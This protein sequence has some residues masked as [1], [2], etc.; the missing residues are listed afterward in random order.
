MFKRLRSKHG[1][2]LSPELAFEPGHFYSP[3]VDREYIR[4]HEQHI[5]STNDALLG[6]D[7]NDSSH[8]HILRTIFPRFIRDFDYPEQ[9]KDSDALQGF[10]VNN[11][12][13]SWLDPRTL[14]VLFREWRPARVIEVGSGYSSLLMADVN[15]RFLNG[16]CDI[17][18]I[19]PFPRPFLVRGVPGIAR[20]LTTMVQDVPL[21]LFEQLNRGDVLFIDSSH[22]AKT[23]SDVNYL[24][25]QVLP[26]LAPGVLIHVHDIFLPDE[27][28]KDWVLGENRSWNEQYV[29]RAL[30]MYTTGFRI[31]FGCNLAYRRHFEDLRRALNRPDGAVWGG[32][33]LWLT[34]T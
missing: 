8:V 24:V 28:P 16:A 4:A 23:G 10:Y 5:W 21:S 30:L 26:R 18:C 29:I 31:V 3:I 15:R 7:V 25:F 20:L 22:V 33:S 27:Y 17:T 14:F 2:Q 19:E 13:F 12:Q 11:S 6:V 34:R 9:A 1:E 32:G